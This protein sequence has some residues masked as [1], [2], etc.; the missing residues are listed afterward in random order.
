MFGDACKMGILLFL[1]LEDN[2]ETAL[3]S[4]GAGYAGSLPVENPAGSTES[5]IARSDI[6]RPLGRVL[7]NHCGT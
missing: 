4:V 1:S 7:T 2:R 6:Q 3:D 5:G